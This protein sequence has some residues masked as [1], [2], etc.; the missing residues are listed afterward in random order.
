MKATTSD[1]GFA[2]R[3][4]LEGMYISAFTPD[5]V[6]GYREAPRQFSIDFIDVSDPS[7]PRVFLG[8]GQI[9]SVRIFSDYAPE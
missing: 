2:I 7:N 9:F 4:F 3:D 1:I 8:N 5:G 6:E